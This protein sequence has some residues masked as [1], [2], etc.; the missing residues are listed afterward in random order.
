MQIVN[1]SA[2]VPYSAN[3]MYELVKN[4][5]SY[6]GFLPWCGNARILEYLPD[7]VRASINISKG[8]VNKT[9]STRNRFVQDS[10]IEMNLEEGPFSELHGAWKFEPIGN[11]G[12]RVSLYLEFD[13]SSTLLRMTVGPVFSIIADRLVDAFVERAE[14]IYG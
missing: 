11:E 8:K 14:V 5:E 7:G 4:V 1:R 3:Q 10:S 2:L 13:F 9:F 12:C 6:P